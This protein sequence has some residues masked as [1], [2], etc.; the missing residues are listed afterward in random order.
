MNQPTMINASLPVL[1]EVVEKTS[2]WRYNL[3][4]GARIVSTKSQ[5]P[6]Q[7][8]AQYYA[9][10][11]G[12]SGGVININGLYKRDNGAALSDG[13]GLI[14][15]VFSSQ[16]YEQSNTSVNAQNADFS[17]LFDEIKTKL[18]TCKNASDFEI[19]CDMLLALKN[20]I[21]SVPFFYEN[22]YC[23]A[24]IRPFNAGLELYL[25]FSI[26]APL[27]ARVSGGVFSAIITPY[28]N[29][30]A[31]LAKELNCEY[32]ESKIEP[33]Y[34]ANSGVFNFKG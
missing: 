5:V 19:F 21:I 13:V 18:A 28:I 26:Y 20:G 8:G 31:L 9:N 11:R 16:G 3:R 27:I 10:I 6:L 1:I 14:E 22:R 25:L 15:R 34:S 32:Y 7:I 29:Y 4:F 33:F 2:W 30:S 23:L 17:W 24:Q 12:Q